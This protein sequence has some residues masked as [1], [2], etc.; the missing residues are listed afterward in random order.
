M[1]PSFMYLADKMSLDQV[2]NVMN[3][4]TVVWFVTASIWMWKSD[5]KA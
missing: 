2:K 4:S 3:A 5:S 1:V